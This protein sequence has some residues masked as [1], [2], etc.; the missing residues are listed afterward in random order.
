MSSREKGNQKPYHAPDGNRWNGEPGFLYGLVWYG[1]VWY[2]T[3]RYGIRGVLPA[4]VAE[5]EPSGRTYVREGKSVSIRSL[6]A[7]CNG[8]FFTVTYHRY[9]AVRTRSFAV[10]LVCL[11]LNWPTK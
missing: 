11:A 5:G 6:F 2:G 7:I 8:R 10:G 3:V 1:P 9:Y 4:A